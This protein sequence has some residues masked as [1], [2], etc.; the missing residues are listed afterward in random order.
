MLRRIA[1]PLLASVFIADGVRAIARPHHEVEHLPH[2]EES[3]TQVGQQLPVQLSADTL[4]RVLG[5]A[6]VGA[7][8]ALACGVAPRVA[9]GA[10]AVLQLPTAL[11]RHPFWTKTGKPRRDDLAGLWRDGAILGGLLLAVVDTDGKPSLAWRAEHAAEQARK[12]AS[13]AAK[14][15]TKDAKHVAS[16]VTKGAKHVAHDVTKDAK[17]AAKEAKR[18]ARRTVKDAKGAVHTAG[19]R[20][21]SALPH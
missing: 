19:Q 9:A 20:I 12:D 15:V 5:V 16:D 14:H 21:E 1:R 8:L 18:A 3:L 7:G 4:V 13:R 6:K 17:R 2:A 10:L 11:A